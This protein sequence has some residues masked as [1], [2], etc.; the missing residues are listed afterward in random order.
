MRLWGIDP[1]LLCKRHLL[2]EHF[3]THTFR[4]AIVSGR[5]LAGYVARGLVDTS[6][7]K[8]H[9]DRLAAEL[10]RRGYKHSSEFEDLPRTEYVGRI[11]VEKN[12]AELA[13]RCPNCRALILGG[14]G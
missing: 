11:D 2:G 4:G 3:E 13:A 5:S 8:A 10:V 6:I 9:H 12:L 14:K 1:A 7:L